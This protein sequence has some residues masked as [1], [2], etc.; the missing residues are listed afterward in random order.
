M[1]RKHD[2]TGMVER[3]SAAL[4]DRLTSVV[5]YGPTTHGD[6]YSRLPPGYMLIVLADLSLDSLGRLA[7]PVQWWLR[8][9]EPMPRVF[10]TELLRASADVYPI[11]LV[12]LLQAR[13]ILFGS[14]PVADL[15]IDR[16]YLRLQ[17]ER[18][19]REKLMRLREGYIECHGRRSIRRD[20]GDLIA[21]SY[22][23]FVRIFRACLVLIDAPPAEHDHDVVTTLCTWLDRSA[24]PFLAAEAIAREGARD[25]PQPTFA[26]YYD[27]LTAVVERI[28]RLILKSTGRT[29]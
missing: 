3:T 25:D 12:E 9:G 23:S 24:A 26:A 21:V 7:D 22:A 1:T 6:E 17:C 10:T 5:S 19:L 27:A 2:E 28:D 13:R 16:A 18:E 11:E 4:G 14:D 15:A 20:L 29:P 8:R